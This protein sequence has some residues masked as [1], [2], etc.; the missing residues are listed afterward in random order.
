MRTPWRFNDAN[1]SMADPPPT[2]YSRPWSRR[3]IFDLREFGSNANVG[4]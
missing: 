3:A 1:C 2:E 4:A